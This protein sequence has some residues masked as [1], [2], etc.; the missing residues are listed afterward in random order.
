MKLQLIAC[1][2]ATAITSS[3]FG[4]IYQWVDGD[5]DGD[6]SLWLSA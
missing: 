4:D 1:A 6:G 5:V 2:T 3:S